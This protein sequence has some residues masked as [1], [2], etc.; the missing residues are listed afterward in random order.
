[1][2]T[3]GELERAA[4]EVAVEVRVVRLDLGDQLLDE[5]LMVTPGIEDT[6]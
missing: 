2:G 1:V 3:F 6:H 5:V 4:D